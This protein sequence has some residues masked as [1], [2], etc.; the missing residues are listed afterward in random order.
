M[1][2]TGIVG[3]L[4]FIPVLIVT[5][6]LSYLGLLLKG[7]ETV[8]FTLSKSYFKPASWMLDLMRFFVPENPSE[9]T[10]KL[11]HD[12]P[13]TTIVSQALNELFAT[14]A[15]P[16]PPPCNFKKDF[17]QLCENIE[18]DDDEKAKQSID[19]MLYHGEKGRIFLKY[20]RT[21]NGLTAQELAT[22]TGKENK[23]NLESIAHY[24]EMKCGALE[25]HLID[26]FNS[27]CE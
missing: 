17:Q 1:G 26:A 6:P 18:N 23:E 2:L 15:T 12:N 13:E 16:A 10:F 11:W 24:I 5:T 20:Q 7:E 3:I 8:L 14:P 19:A 21:E 9:K 4:S 25:S 27:L 22:K